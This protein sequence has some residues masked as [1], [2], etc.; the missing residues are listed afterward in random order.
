MAWFGA[1]E[2]VPDQFKDFLEALGPFLYFCRPNI[3]VRPS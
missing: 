3:I 1:R 2:L